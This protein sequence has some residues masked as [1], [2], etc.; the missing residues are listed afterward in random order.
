MAVSAVTPIPD[1]CYANFADS[2][3]YRGISLSSIIGKVFDL[4]VFDRYSVSL[5]TSDLQFSFKMNRSTDIIMFIN[6]DRVHFI[7]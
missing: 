5:L 4:I 1:D 3:N 2:A 7:L 6:S